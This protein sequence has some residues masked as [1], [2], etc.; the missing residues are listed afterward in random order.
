MS[1]SNKMFFIHCQSP[2]HVGTGQGVGIIDM[3]IMRERVTSWP[4]VPG[5]SI[6]GVL[7]EYCTLL[8]KDH[9]GNEMVDVAFGKVS[10]SRSESADSTSAGSL[11]FTDGRMLAFP[12]ASGYGTFAYVSCPMALR[13]L[14]RDSSAAGLFIGGLD[15]ELIN[16]WESILREQGDGSP[17]LIG[18]QANNVLVSNKKYMLMSLNSPLRRMVD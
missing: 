7:R 2:V 1:E 17:A 9:R 4:L 13:R 10:E 14:L 5:S 6:K 3:P 12:V 16:Q 18:K 11:A 8:A 15:Q